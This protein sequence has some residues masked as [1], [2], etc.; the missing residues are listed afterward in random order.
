MWD[1]AQTHDPAPVPLQ[2]FTKV[3]SELLLSPVSCSTKVFLHSKTESCL[4][5][6][7]LSAGVF[8]LAVRCQLP[9]SLGSKR[10]LL[11][12]LRTTKPHSHP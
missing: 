12:L 1:P 4:K 7:R 2:A 8:S 5:A 9:G 11:V 10:A 3:S 6:R